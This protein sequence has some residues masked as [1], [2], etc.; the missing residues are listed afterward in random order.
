[1]IASLNKKIKI[2]ETKKLPEAPK[3]QGTAV[4]DT[5]EK[6]EAEKDKEL[7]VASEGEELQAV[8]KQ[9][10]V[11]KRI[12]L[13]G[14]RGTVAEEKTVFMKRFTQVETRPGGVLGILGNWALAEIA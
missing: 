3:R 11:A 6:K 1:M 12:M 2:A 10:K 14:R 7:E 9:R 5:A 4:G 8:R 13:E